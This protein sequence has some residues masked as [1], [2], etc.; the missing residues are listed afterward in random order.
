MTSSPIFWLATSVV[1]GVYLTTLYPSV[2]GGDSGELI[3]ESCH[4]GT[5]HPPGYP[6]FTLVSWG[7]TQMLGPLLGGTPAWRSNLLGAMFDTISAAC[8]FLCVEEWL[9]PGPSQLVRFAAPAFARIAGAVAAMGLFALSPLIWMYASHA[10]VFAMN[11]ALIGCI[12]FL[13]IRFGRTKSP[14]VAELGAFMCGLALTN[15]HTAI[16]YEGECYFYFMIEDD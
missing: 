4:L 3:A 13:S 8:V 5:A 9:R 11:N 7:F 16:L 6:L 15:Q 2:A 1:F 12:V 14:R 10:E